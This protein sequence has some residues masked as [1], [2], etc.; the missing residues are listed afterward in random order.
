MKRVCAPNNPAFTRLIDCLRE[1]PSAGLDCY[2][3]MIIGTDTLQRMHRHDSYR[4]TNPSG[5]GA[6]DSH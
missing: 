2:A 5:Y 4:W 1:R 6:T 3:M